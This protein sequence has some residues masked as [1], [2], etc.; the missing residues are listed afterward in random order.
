MK[1]LFLHHI[2][3]KGKFDHRDLKTTSGMSIQVVERGTHNHNSGPDF[4]NAQ[5]RLNGVLWAGNVEI[6]VIASDWFKHGH[7]YDDSYNNTILHVVYED[8]TAIQTKS[9]ETPPCLELKTRIQ[10]SMYRKYLD[11]SSQI[12]AIPCKNHRP[13]KFTEEIEEMMAF[14]LNERLIKKA[15]EIIMMFEQMDF[16]WNQVHYHY[17]CK[18]MGFRVNAEPMAELARRT[19]LNIIQKNAGNLKAVKAILLGQADMLNVFKDPQ[20]QDL[21]SEYHFYRHKYKLEPVNASSW[22]FM[23]M[24]PGNFPTVK[25]AQLAEMIFSGKNFFSGILNAGSFSEMARVYC[26]TPNEGNGSGPGNVSARSLAINVGVPMLFAWGYRMGDEKLKAK[27]VKILQQGMPENN[28]ITRDWES[29]GFPNNSAAHSQALQGLRKEF[30]EQK[31]CLD[32][33]IGLRII[34]T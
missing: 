23:R 29:I 3:E 4:I 27:A 28:K 30:C 8:D 31:R 16:D 26:C 19:P 15:G 24:R 33:R 11:L 13:L 1:E 10:E 7:Q 2:W 18:Y 12:D 5:L 14:A 34:S 32:C 20:I 17:L 25:V 6:H 21:K 22:K 9:G